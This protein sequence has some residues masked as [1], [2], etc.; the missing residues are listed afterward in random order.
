MKQQSQHCILYQKIWCRTISNLPATL[1]E[2]LTPTVRIK[3]EVFVADIFMGK[4]TF[5]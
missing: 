2:Q 3:Y 1:T 5:S 4:R